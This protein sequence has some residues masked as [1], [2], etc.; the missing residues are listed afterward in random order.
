[1]A[2][3]RVKYI[4]SLINSR[5]WV[6]PKNLMY[7]C[8]VSHINFPNKQIFIHEQIT[9]QKHYLQLA[10]LFVAGKWMQNTE[11]KLRLTKESLQFT[12]E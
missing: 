7:E 2:L 10:K 11:L 12:N 4:F 3:K 6:K 5:Q 9:L 1:M 8:L